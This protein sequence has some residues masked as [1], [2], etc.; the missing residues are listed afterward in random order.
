MTK[1]VP[2][3]QEDLYRASIPGG[4]ATFFRV[5][6]LSNR[7]EEE[8]SIAGTPAE[9]AINKIRTARKVVGA[10]GESDT[11]ESLFGADVHLTREEARDILY[12]NNTLGWVL[13]KSWSLKRNGEPLPLPQSVDDLLDL[14]K[15]LKNAIV[16]HAAKIFAADDE[17]K[18][19]SFSI[20]PGIEDQESPIGA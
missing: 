8:L 9:D 20:D 12:L 15:E 6:E 5:K 14:P 13:L 19:D 10:D 1:P 4:T 7:R 17:I 18:K 16:Q 2:K 3:K 11:S